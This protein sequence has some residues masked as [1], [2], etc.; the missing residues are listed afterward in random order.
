MLTGAI[1][2]G[3]V[4]LLVLIINTRTKQQ[5][6]SK[7]QQVLPANVEY[8]GL[9]HYATGNRY[10]KS[11]KYFDSYGV[12]YL[13]GNSAYYKTSEAGEPIKFNLEECTVSQENNW[14]G[15]KWFS[16]A[17]P[18]GEKHYFNSNKPGAFTSNSDETLKG[19][20]ALKAKSRQ[21]VKS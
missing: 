20:A 18:S 13:T 3:L 10:K 6:F 5:K 9:Y 15:M 17:T 16:I 8:S 19:L 7:I 1:I 11:L 14:R 4:A 2:G 21:T 12:L